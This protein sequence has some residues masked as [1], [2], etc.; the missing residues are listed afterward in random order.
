VA[1]G[2][3]TAG[4]VSITSEELSRPGLEIGR[5]IVLTATTVREPVRPNRTA[6]YR[7]LDTDADWR[8]QL[9]LRLAI[10]GA[11]SSQQFLQRRVATHRR[12]AQAGHGA[13]FGAFVNGQLRS[14]LGVFS[15][16]GGF[17]RYQNV[18]THP[19][20]RNQGLAGTL[21]NEAGRYALT[22][23]GATTLVIVADPSYHA[24]GIYRSAGF[25]DTEMQVGLEGA[26]PA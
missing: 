10:D 19:E 9:D 1:L 3:D 16:G 18:G 14:S 7:P 17:V 23:L 12:L 24:I 26:G 15:A 2:V 5:D 21:M 22:S 13:W 6:H 20:A 11:T 4:E 25:T 8:A